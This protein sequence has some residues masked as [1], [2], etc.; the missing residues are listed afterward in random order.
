MSVQDTIAL[1]LDAFRAVE[2]R[3]EQ[4]W[5]AIIHPQFEIVWPPSLPY[6]GQVHRG[7]A[8]GTGSRK[9]TWRLTWSETWEP[10]QPTEAER[11]MSPRVIAASDNTV[12]V[13]W[14]QRG[15]SPSGERFD[16]PVLGLYQVR[17]GKLA[18][19]QMFYFDTVAVVGFLAGA[20]R[21]SSDTGHAESLH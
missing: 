19:A 4:R 13:L 18:H 10:L 17:D 14:Q 11:R 3:D 9:S 1:V 12:V 21:L 6:G 5:R 15:I 20:Y 2:C 16:E 7:E 8:P